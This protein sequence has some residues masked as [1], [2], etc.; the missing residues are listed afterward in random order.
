MI[1]LRGLVRKAKVLRSHAFRP[2]KIKQRKR[3]AFITQRYIHRRAVLVRAAEKCAAVSEFRGNIV[4][5]QCRGPEIQ[6]SGSCQD[7]A[8]LSL[9][10][11]Q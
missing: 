2:G 10:C 8:D 7:K 1:T 9:L 11:C 6:L 5:L 3:A 4:C